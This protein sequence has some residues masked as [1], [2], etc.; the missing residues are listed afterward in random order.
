MKNKL[1][2]IVFYLLV[3]G[4]QNVLT[5]QTSNNT[6]TLWKGDKIVN[7][8][9]VGF[10]VAPGYGS[11][12]MDGSLTSLF[13]LRGGAQ[14]NSR[15]A[16]GAYY[17]TSL[18]RINPESEILSGVYM[19]Y[20]STGGFVEFTMF[21]D[22]LFHVTLPV[23]VGYGEVEMDNETGDAGLDEAGFF[24]I[25][26]SALLEVNLHKY[27]R[28]NVGTGYRFVGDMNYRNFDQSDISGLTGFVGFKFG[29]FR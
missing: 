16:L 2:I 23:Y 1:I 5:G 22:K 3:A 11:T 19:D 4:I 29:L 9:N 28:L 15:F 21:S 26:P 18:N 14:Y 10:F 20:W 7:L 17:N 8:N 24:Q 12:Q 27:V 13:T 6:E 25:E